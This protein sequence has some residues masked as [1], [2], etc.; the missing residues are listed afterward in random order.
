MWAPESGWTLWRREIAN[1]KRNT[2]IIFVETLSGIH[3]LGKP[4]RR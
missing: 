3:P 1:V 4:I 2:Y